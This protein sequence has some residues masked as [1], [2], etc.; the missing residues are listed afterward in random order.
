VTEPTASKG[1]SK[2]RLIA[3]YVALFAITAV[4]AAIVISA[5]DDKKGLESI[6]GGYDLAAPNACLGSP[7]APPKGRPLPA[8]APAQAQVVGPSVDVKQSGEFVNL[9]NA[10]KTVSGKLR[11]EGDELAG[12]ARKL[13]GDVNCADDVKPERFYF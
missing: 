2:S 9:S 5:G 4:V 10:Q 3:F 8:T 11:F 13:T 12:G 7:P 1:A 6:A